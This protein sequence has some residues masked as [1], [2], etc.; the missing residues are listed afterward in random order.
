MLYSLPIKTVWDV[1]SES[2]QKGDDRLSVEK[3]V[4]A[5]YDSGKLHNVWLTVMTNEWGKPMQ[6]P[7]MI[8]RGA[9]EGACIALTAAIRTFNS[10]RSTDRRV[11]RKRA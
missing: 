11:R 9:T 5:D 7:V 1:M 3:I 2:Q 8:L 4:L 10:Y 6:V